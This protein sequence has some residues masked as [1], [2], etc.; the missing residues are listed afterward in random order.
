M[1]QNGLI[2][3]EPLGFT[4]IHLDFLQV[5]QASGLSNSASGRIA[6]AGEHRAGRPLRQAGGLFHPDNERQPL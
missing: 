2:H 6:V 3:L 4:W 5:E 1:F